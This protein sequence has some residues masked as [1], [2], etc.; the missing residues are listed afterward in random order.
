M[1]KSGLTFIVSILLT[2]TG[3]FGQA[4]KNYELFLLEENNG[5]CSHSLLLFADSTYCSES[6]CEA[7]SHFSFGKWSQKKNIITFTLAN[8]S[9]FNFIQKVERE[10]A[11]GKYTSV[12]LFDKKGNNITSKI[13][14]G[15]YVEGKGMYSMELDST[16][17]K[18][19][20]LKHVNALLVITTLQ[21]FTK[22]KLAIDM[23]SSGVYKIYLNVSGDW[24]F[25][26]NSTWEGNQT[27][28]LARKDNYLISKEPDRI[29]DGKL[30]NS[31][32]VMQAQ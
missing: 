5:L 4:K 20:G 22:Q 23:D 25:N 29:E 17:T 1:F 28:S 12:S 7:S 18:R 32:Y 21:R 24:N 14:I 13:V 16:Y 30:V 6:G 9:T 2:V 10:P 31:K 11:N 8:T 19:T 27:F 26:K 15:Q 3:L